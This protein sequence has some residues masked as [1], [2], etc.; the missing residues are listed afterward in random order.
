MI[1]P[2]DSIDLS[3]YSISELI[4]LRDR[5]T[6]MIPTSDL[7]D[8]DL[9]K[10]LVTAFYNGKE[11][12][13]NAKYDDGVPLSQKAS[14]INSIVA[15]LKALSDAQKALFNIERQR[16]LENC[17]AKALEQFPELHDEFFE[18]YEQELEP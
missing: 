12:L 4:R 13:E 16:R 15:S 6:E 1:I 3:E 9:Q 17:L 14:A 18:Y 10:E 2:V 8:I 5:V 11:I 7:E